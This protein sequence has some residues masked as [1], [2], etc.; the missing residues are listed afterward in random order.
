MEKKL[1]TVDYSICTLKP[2]WWT[3]GLRGIISLIFGMVALSFPTITAYSLTLLFGAYSIINGIIYIISG[4]NLARRKQRWAGLILAGV[5][6]NIVGLFSLT[7]PHLATIS[8]SIFLW[9]IIATW[10]LA[11]GAF[12]IS[13]AIRLRREIPNEWLLALNGLILLI[14]GLIAFALLW[15]NPLVSVISLSLFVG[16]NAMLSGVMLLLLSSKLYKNNSLATLEED[17]I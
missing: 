5:L 12:E 8:L 9:T 15:I 4:I 16:I 10:A 7:V 2:N 14:F 1:T 6:G 13:S 11:T 17:P 3:F